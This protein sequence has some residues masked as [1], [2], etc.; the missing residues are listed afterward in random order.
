MA[1]KLMKSPDKIISGVCGG[2]ANSLGWDKTLVRILYVIL[3]LC[4][5]LLPGIIVYLV[6]MFIMPHG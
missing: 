4:T 3:T 1:T 6:L 2:I 5:G